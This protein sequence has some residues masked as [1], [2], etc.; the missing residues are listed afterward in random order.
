MSL[1][2]EENIQ[3]SDILYYLN[4]KENA[5]APKITDKGT[6]AVQKQI[7]QVFVQ[8]VSEIGLELLEG[9]RQALDE[10]ARKRTRCSVFPR[11]LRS[12]GSRNWKRPPQL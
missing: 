4:E 12:L 2:S 7:D 9:L 1:F 6:S 5:I 10:E 3:R 11:N 8:T